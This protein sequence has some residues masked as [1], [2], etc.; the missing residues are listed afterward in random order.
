MW[1]NLRDAAEAMARDGWTR[2][3]DY[4]WRKDVGGRLAWV[5]LAWR[6]ETLVPVVMEE[7][8]TAP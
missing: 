8:W 4:F 3:T 6:G 2:H 7:H 1:T 5:E